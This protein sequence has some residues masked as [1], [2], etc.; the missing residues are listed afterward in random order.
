[1]P[2]FDEQYKKKLIERME[3]RHE[4]GELPGVYQMGRYYSPEQRLEEVKSG[5]EAG[6]E[7]LFAE[8]KL[9]DELKK[10]M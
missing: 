2:M 4:K 7:F 8:K 3:K 6:E 5:T 9:M 1:M 10:R